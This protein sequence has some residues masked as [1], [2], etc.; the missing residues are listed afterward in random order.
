MASAR[1]R[2]VVAACV[3]TVLSAV[4]PA[5]AQPDQ[6]VPILRPT[7]SLA[8]PKPRAEP[9]PPRPSSMAYQPEKCARDAQGM[10]YFAIRRR[11]FRQPADHLGYIMLGKPEEMRLLP[12][13]PRPEEPKGCPDHPIQGLVFHLG[14]ISAPPDDPTPPISQHADFMSVV[15]NGGTTAVTSDDSFDYY[16][17]LAPGR[18]NS[19]A[20][21]LGCTR[22]APPI[23]GYYQAIEYRA[24]NGGKVGFACLSGLTATQ[25]T[26]CQGGYRLHMDMV[27]N[28]KFSL[29]A[30]PV[31]EFIAADQELRRRFDVAEVKNYPWATPPGDTDTGTS[32]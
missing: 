19:N 23:N 3:V 12:T 5:L 16:C 6:S 10:V 9:T 7:V 31:T 28:F 17:S 14:R 21:W 26:I 2:L 1:Q 13:P 18:D 32:R 22:A 24:P 27:V 11:V 8:D 29:R 4:W 15:V 30:L 20:G 25:P